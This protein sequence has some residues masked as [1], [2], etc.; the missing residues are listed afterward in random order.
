MEGFLKTGLEEFA[1]TVEME[2]RVL[3]CQV[4][5]GIAV[6]THHRFDAG[7]SPLSEGPAVLDCPPEG[8]AVLDC[9]R[10]FDD[11]V[12]EGACCQLDIQRRLIDTPG[13]SFSSLVVHRT[14]NGICV[15]GMLE[16][17]SSEIDIGKVV[18]DVSGVENVINQVLVR[19]RMAPMT[20]EC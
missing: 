2:A 17:S 14:E 1:S 3:W 7:V 20:I 5:G 10:G 6:L 4:D 16:T 12:P 11:F 19:Q 18:R 15:H 9:P 8:A 13:L